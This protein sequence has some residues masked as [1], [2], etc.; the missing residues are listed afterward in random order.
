LLTPVRVDWIAGSAPAEG[1]PCAGRAYVVRRVAAGVGIEWF[2]GERASISS[3]VQRSRSP[4]D[5]SPDL[6]HHAK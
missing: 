1:H 2:A 5:E 4:R 6:M 3:E